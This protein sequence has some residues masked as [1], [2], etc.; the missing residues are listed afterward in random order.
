MAIFLFVLLCMGMAR[1]LVLIL[2][3][4]DLVKRIG[5]M[6]GAGVFAWPSIWYGWFSGLIF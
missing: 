2:I 6:I 4:K 3:E 1:N 5:I